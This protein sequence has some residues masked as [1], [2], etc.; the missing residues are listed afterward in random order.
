MNPARTLVA[1]VALL[2]AL[3]NLYAGVLLASSGVGL[4]SKALYERGL[5]FIGGVLIVALALGLGYQTVR[6]LRWGSGGQ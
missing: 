5:L 3:L 6:L 4:G 2:Y 1:V